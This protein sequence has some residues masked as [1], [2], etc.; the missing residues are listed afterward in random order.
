MVTPKW[1]CQFLFLL[2]LFCCFHHRLVHSLVWWKSGEKG[3]DS[4]LPV[5]LSDLA[6]NEKLKQKKYN[7]W[8][9]SLE[10]TLY[11]FLATHIT[12][13]DIKF[14][15]VL[16]YFKSFLANQGKSLSWSSWKNKIVLSTCNVEISKQQPFCRNILNRAIVSYFRFGCYPHSS[17]KI[18]KKERER[19]ER[20]KHPKKE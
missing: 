18:K 5:K 4:R 1:S 16:N 2:Y 8:I 7:Q 12:K 9:H 6:R 3:F 20:K 15:T 17:K 13:D 19:K 11:F 10:N 14:E